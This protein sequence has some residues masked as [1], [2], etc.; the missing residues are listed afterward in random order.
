MNNKEDF[1]NLIQKLLINIGEDVTRKGLLKTPERCVNM[2]S[3]LLCKTGEDPKEE[4]D[5]F[6][7]SETDEPILIKD[8]EFYS[9]CEHHM[10]PF[11]GLCHVA[12]IPNKNKITGLSKIVRVVENASKR[13]QIQ[14]NMTNMISKAIDEK[15]NPKGTY[16]IIEAEHMCIAMRGIK[17]TGS[18]TITTKK[19][20]IFETNSDLVRNIDL[21]IKG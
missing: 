6:F 18:K 13:L 17:K 21:K 5:T 3:E 14:E 15:L 7:E 12:Y 2:Y 9:L 10:L 11:Y 16:V 1:K 19:T 4:I 20:G 8:I